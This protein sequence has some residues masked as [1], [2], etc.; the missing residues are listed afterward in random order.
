MGHEEG[1]W[2]G[3]IERGYKEGGHFR[4]QYCDAFIHQLLS[5][6]H[7]G[8]VP[9]PHHPLQGLVMFLQGP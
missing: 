7:V 1:T 8:F 2:K 9:L 3:D 6:L 4:T 5:T